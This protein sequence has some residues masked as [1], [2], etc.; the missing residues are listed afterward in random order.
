MHIIGRIG[1]CVVMIWLSQVSWVAM[2]CVIALRKLR[3]LPFNKVVGQNTQSFQGH[4][5]D[6]MIDIYPTKN[7]FFSREIAS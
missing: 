5:I 6:F 2:M 7:S 1:H 3:Q 4:S